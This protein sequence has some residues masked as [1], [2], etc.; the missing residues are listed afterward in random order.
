MT[1]RKHKRKPVKQYTDTSMDAALK[2]IEAGA[3]SIRLASKT[4]AVPKTTL[5]RLLDRIDSNVVNIATRE[6]SKAVR[7]QDDV[8]ID[9]KQLL[10][11]IKR[12]ADNAL[13]YV[14]K[15]ADIDQLSRVVERIFRIEQG[16]IEANELKAM[17]EQLERRVYNSKNTVT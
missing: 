7:T 11:K 14:S 5:L 4:F 15:V 13:N 3:M 6:R 1:K 2:A 12:S 16:I 17:L 9:S 8:D 10:H